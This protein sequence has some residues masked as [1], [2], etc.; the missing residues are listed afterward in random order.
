MDLDSRIAL[1][2]PNGAGKS[3]LLKLMTGELEALDGM[4]KRHNHLKIGMYHQHLTDLLDDKLN[5]LEYMVSQPICFQLELGSGCM[6]LCHDFCQIPHLHR[7]IPEAL[8][9]P[10]F[11]LV[12]TDSLQQSG[13]SSRHCWPTDGTYFVQRGWILLLDTLRKPCADPV[14]LSCCCAFSHDGIPC[15]AEVPG[16]H[17]TLG[18]QSCYCHLMHLAQSCH[19]LP[20]SP[21]RSQ[22]ALVIASA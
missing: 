11:R 6:R 19:Q 5:P 22:P 7:P 4:V 12:P 9:A 8:P 16:E 1:V 20:S 14:G 13:L 15:T 18:C 17:C 10:L 2:G 21:S 3:T